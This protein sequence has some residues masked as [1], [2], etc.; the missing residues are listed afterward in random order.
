[1][2]LPFTPRDDGE[3]FKEPDPLADADDVDA[4]DLDDLRVGAHVIY[5]S[6]SSIDLA[7]TTPE[8]FWTLFGTKNGKAGTVKWL[9]STIKKLKDIKKG[10]PQLSLFR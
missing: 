1:M 8:V 2:V 10:M 9:T 3:Q 6:L 7:K 5:G 4:V